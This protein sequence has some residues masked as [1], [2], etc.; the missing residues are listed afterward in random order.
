MQHTVQFQ[1]MDEHRY[2]APGASDG[3]FTLGGGTFAGVIL[4]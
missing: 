3:L 4:L 2:F 1:L